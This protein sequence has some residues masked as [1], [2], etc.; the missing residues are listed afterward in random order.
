M[1]QQHRAPHQSERLTT[2]RLTRSVFSLCNSH[3][4]AGFVLRL[5]QCLCPT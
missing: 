4:V 3:Q 2:A 1:L 5:A